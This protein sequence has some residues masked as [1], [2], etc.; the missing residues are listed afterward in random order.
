MDTT[1]SPEEAFRLGSF[2]RC[3]W[4][5]IALGYKLRI[6]EMIGYESWEEYLACEHW[7][8]NYQPGRFQN[9]DLAF[10]A[11]Y[12]MSVEAISRITTL[13]PEIIRAELATANAA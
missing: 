9:P 4:I 5:A 7:E 3:D 8:L 13:E 11:S 2:M 10:W 6:W 12:G 1:L